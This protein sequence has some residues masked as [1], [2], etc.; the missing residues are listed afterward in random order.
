MNRITAHI[1]KTSGKILNVYYTAGYP[2]LEDTAPIGKALADAGV[3]LLEIGI[4]FSDPVADGPV[5]QAAN[6]VALTNGMTLALLLEQVK[7]MR[8]TIHIPIIL[9]GYF[10]QVLQYGVTAFLAACQ[11]A[12]VDGLILP[13]LPDTVYQKQYQSLFEA[14]GL[15]P[16]FLVTP[17]TP[18]DRIRH[19]ARL[20]GGFLY[21]LSSASI[22]GKAGLA[23]GQNAWFSRLASLDLPLPVLVGF[24]ISTAEDIARV[25]QYADGCIIGSAFLRHIQTHGADTSSIQ[26]FIQ[27]LHPHSQPL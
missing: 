13:D 25:N 15:A 9:M 6:Q 23:Q 3:D 20:S 27:S 22:S 18:D 10:N 26:T 7:A 21:A 14:H 16:I 19:L 1:Q 17:Q 5:I 8:P 2:T 12:G 4:P 11:D 24:G